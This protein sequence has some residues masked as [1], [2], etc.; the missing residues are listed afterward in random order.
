MIWI[1]NL[2]HIQVFILELLF[3]TKLKRKPCFALRFISCMMF[4]VVLPVAVPD[5]FG[6]K[7]LVVGTIPLSFMFMF[8][9]SLIIIR[10]S[11]C[12]G[13][14]QLLFYGCLAHTFQHIGHCVSRFFISFYPA[15]GSTGLNITILAVMIVLCLVVLR[16]RDAFI[17]RETA[18]LTNRNLLF[19][20]LM[21]TVIVYVISVSS[22]SVDEKP[23]GMTILEFFACILILFILLDA[24][25]LRKAEQDRMI[26]EQL[27]YQEQEQHRVSHATVE[28]INRKCHDLKHQITALRHMD[29]DERKKS[30]A[31]LEKAVMFY[32]HFPKSG[33]ESL[34][35]ILAEKSI[36]AEQ[37][38]ISIDCIIDGSRLDF[39]STEDLYSLFGNALDN[40]IEAAAREREDVPRI[41]TLHGVSKGKLYSIHIE[42][43]CTV[44]PVFENGLPCTVKDNKD[45]HGYGTQS[46]RYICNKYNGTLKASWEDGV[47]NLDILLPIKNQNAGDSPERTEEREQSPV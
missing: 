2:F 31:D 38:H 5:G 29:A 6:F 22:V 23:I 8:V 11:F 14:R 30:I 19:F 12:I 15:L 34:D 43:P 7:P 17:A 9:F 3:C 40:A 21:S 18:E 26:I 42:N 16:V 33:L 47:F 35:A 20:A 45:Y 36:L 4:Y 44:S 27:L 13:W 46:M 41:I 25:R 32:D 24:F 10:I 37:L 1:F 39:V 28:I